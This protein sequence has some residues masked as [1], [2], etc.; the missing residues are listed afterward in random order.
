[1]EVEIRSTPPSPRVE[2]S[3]LKWYYEDSFNI[4]WS[5][6]LTED[7]EPLPYDENDL[8]V[9]SFFTKDRKLIIEF[10][11]S[12]ITDNTVVL[13]FTE[14]VSKLFTPGQYYYCVKYID[15]SG[16]VSTIYANRKIEVEWCH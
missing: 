12:H 2:N 3:V 13:Q 5:I 16:R 15:G 10:E 6:A 4:T 1:M 9:F 8:L 14:E 7:G 11:F